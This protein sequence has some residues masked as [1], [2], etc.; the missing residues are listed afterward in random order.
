MRELSQVELEMVGGGNPLVVGVIA[1]GAVLAVGGLA[2]VAYGVSQGCSG[3]IEF[4]SEAVKI[5]VTCP[6]I[7]K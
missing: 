1:V 7:T 5:E 2:L 6:P 4:S 3:S